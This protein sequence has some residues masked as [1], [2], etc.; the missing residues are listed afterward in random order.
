MGMALPE[1][2]AARDAYV[3]QCIREGKFEQDWMPLTHMEGENTIT[4]YVMVDALK[5][6]GVRVSVTAEL[7][8]QIADMTGA[9]LLTPKVADLIYH[10]SAFKPGPQPGE[11][12]NTLA[13][14]KAHSKAV[15]AA[16]ARYT[17]Y[18]PTTNP[19]VGCVGKHWVLSDTLP[20][21]FSYGFPQAE[22]YGWHFQGGTTYQ[23]IKGYPCV[24]GLK[25]PSTGLVYY[26]IQDDADAHNMK[27]GDYSQD[28][29]LMQE[30]CDV[31]GEQRLVVEVLADPVLAH[32]I[33]HTGVLR[34][35]RQPGVPVPNPKVLYLP[36]IVIT[37]STI[38]P[39]MPEG[40]A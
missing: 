23:G 20:G 14:V 24:S 12:T 7:A 21:K 16:L 17:T 32:L 37:A 3:L 28:L 5:V 1:D 6:D 27:H 10:Y 22:N 25:D 13:R 35:T 18:D 31:N 34:T 33:S 30:L 4:L 8:Q 26:V 9:L 39:T 11:C 29:V 36:A 2:P 40:T 15:D 19:I 38:P